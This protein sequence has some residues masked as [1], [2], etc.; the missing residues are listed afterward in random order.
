MAE[1]ALRASL[2]ALHR[3]VAGESS[4]GDALHR[5]LAVAVDAVGAEQAGL[6]VLQ[7]DGRPVTAVHVGAGAEPIDR[8]QYGADRGPCLEAFRSGTVIRV[9]DAAR[10]RRWP[11]WAAAAVDNGVRSSLSLPLVVA[12]RRIGALNL[13]APGPSA[14]GE[15]DVVLG[16]AL[17]GQAA[18]AVGNAAAYWEQA[19]LAEQLGVA[20]ASRA[21]IEQ[22]KGV[23]MA[24]TGCDP[25]R[26]FRLL[27][28]ESQVRNL[29]LRDVASDLVARQGG[30]PA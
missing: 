24:T 22:A 26:A 27:R 16:S 2:V 23:I 9:D 15:D 5:I 30:P 29:K 4:L 21:V 10:D 25:E 6:T 12:D 19:T 20:M 3:Y 28:E 13:Y 11:E 17:A 8:D 1:D 18:V 14:F 7:P